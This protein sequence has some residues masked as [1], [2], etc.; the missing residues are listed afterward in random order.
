MARLERTT[1][2][3]HV[4]FRASVKPGLLQ[5]RGRAGFAPDFRTARAL[6]V[7]CVD[8]SSELFGECK[9]TKKGRLR[10]RS[11]LRVRITGLVR[12]NT[13]VRL[14]NRFRNSRIAELDDAVAPYT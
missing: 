1:P 7:L 3:F 10:S 8:Q 2:A 14:G 5:W 4:R 9:G 6:F 12:I 11:R 13:S